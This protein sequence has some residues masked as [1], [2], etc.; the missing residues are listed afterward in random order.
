LI[1]SILLTK[2]FYEDYSNKM[3]FQAKSI[4]K[5]IQKK[6][7]RLTHTRLSILE[8]LEGNTSHPTAETIYQS[9]KPTNPSMS[10]ATVYSTL[11]LLT[12]L[13]VITRLN[14]QKRGTNYDPNTTPHFH[15]YCRHCASIYDIPMERKV[16]NELP[17]DGHTIEEFQGN[18]VGLCKHCS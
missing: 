8:H 16:L 13:G 11:D 9:L 15:F 17:S 12:D 3:T 14:I 4:S 7:H 6:G 2:S 18:L 10:F 5:L 1:L